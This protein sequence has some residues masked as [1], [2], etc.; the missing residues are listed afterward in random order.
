MNTTILSRAPKTHLPVAIIAGL[1]RN[2]VGRAGAHWSTIIGVATSLVS[3][4][5]Y[6]RV[7]YVMFMKDETEETATVDSDNHAARAV[8]FGFAAVVLLIGC[9]PNGLVGLARSAGLM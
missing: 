5:Y 1:F 3:V 2:Q 7:V 9:F 6:M 4:Y 8:A